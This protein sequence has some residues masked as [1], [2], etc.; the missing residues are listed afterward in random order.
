MLHK[1]LH[2]GAQRSTEIISIKNVGVVSVITNDSNIK[3]LRV[4]DVI[5]PYQYK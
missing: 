2:N 1:L 3:D 5:P 4:V